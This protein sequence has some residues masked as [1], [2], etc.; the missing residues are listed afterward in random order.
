MIAGFETGR[1]FNFFSNMSKKPRLGNLIH[2]PESLSEV[3]TI[4]RTHEVDP[5]SVGM[6]AEGVEEIW[7]MNKIP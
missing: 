5:V 7:H 3:T 1:R 4:D 2:M 6:T